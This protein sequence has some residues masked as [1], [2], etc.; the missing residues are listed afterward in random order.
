MRRGIRW[1][2][3]R[4]YQRHQRRLSP[5]EAGHIEHRLAEDRARF[6]EHYGWYPEL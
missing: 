2:L 4:R 3:S 6:M 1:L 5:E